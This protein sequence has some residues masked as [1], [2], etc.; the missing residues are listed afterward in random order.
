[1]NND[2]G[3]HPRREFDKNGV[4]LTVIRENLKLTPTE[5]LRKA[6]ERRRWAIDLQKMIDAQE[7]RA[8]NQSMPAFDGVSRNTDKR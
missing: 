7:S 4:N 5:R 3:L 2:D 1:M 8:K 6:D